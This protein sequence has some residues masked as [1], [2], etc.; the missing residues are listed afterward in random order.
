MSDNIDVDYPTVAKGKR[1]SFF[2]NKEVDQVMTFIVGLLNELMVT[3][4]RVDTLERLLDERGILPQQDVED[5]MPDEE[6]TAAKA[7]FKKEILKNV[8]RMHK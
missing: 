5:F 3:R 7:A 4:D 1:S 2:E 6:Q 8:L